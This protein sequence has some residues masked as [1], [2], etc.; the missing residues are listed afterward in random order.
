MGTKVSFCRSVFLTG[1]PPVR[2]VSQ[3]PCHSMGSSTGHGC[4]SLAGRASS[5]EHISSYMSP[6]QLV[7]PSIS[8]ASPPRVLPRAS[9]RVSPNI[10]SSHISSPG[11][12]RSSLS[13][14][15]PWFNTVPHLFA[16]LGHDGAPAWVSDL[17]VTG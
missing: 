16:V 14:F 3:C 1:F 2:H 5:N 8:K 12:R 6:W 4:S 9:P 13:A 10:L 7:S 15:E 11:G 17:A